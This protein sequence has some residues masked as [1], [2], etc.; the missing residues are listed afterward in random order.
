MRC[1]RPTFVEVRFL[2]DWIY[3]KEKIILRR[4]DHCCDIYPHTRRSEDI[5]VPKKVS[6]VKDTKITLSDLWL[7]DSYTT[8]SYTVQQDVKK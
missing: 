3:T 2:D 6:K 5:W 1:R 7:P 8:R 4:C